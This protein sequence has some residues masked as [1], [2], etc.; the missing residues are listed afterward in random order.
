VLHNDHLGPVCVMFQNC[1]LHQESMDF[2]TKV[3]HI[4]NITANDKIRCRRVFLEFREFVIF[5]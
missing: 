3:Q 5:V 4:V 2:D 1:F